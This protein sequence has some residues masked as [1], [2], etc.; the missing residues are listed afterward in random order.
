MVFLGPQRELNYIGEDPREPWR[1]S[2]FSTMCLAK[3]NQP[4]LYTLWIFIEAIYGKCGLLLPLHFSVDGIAFLGV[5]VAMVRCHGR[6]RPLLRTA[7]R[8]VKQGVISTDYLP[9]NWL[10]KEAKWLVSGFP[11]LLGLSV[12]Y[13]RSEQ[14][15]RYLREIR[16]DINDHGWHTEIW[17][18]PGIEALKM[19][20]FYGLVLSG[21]CTGNHWRCTKK[22]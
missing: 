7:E 19:G 21:K 14:S 5:F 13:N 6:V 4:Y 20:T 16:Q 22:I 15:L 2:P 8:A 17:K 18:K 12:T 10:D 9:W 1:A 11:S 3:M